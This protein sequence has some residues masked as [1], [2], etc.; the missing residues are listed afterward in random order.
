ME[1][2][3]LL[4]YQLPPELSEPLPKPK[5]ITTQFR[6]GDA[7]LVLAEG[8]ETKGT[9]YHIDSSY[10][11]VTIGNTAKPYEPNQIKP[12]SPPP[13]QNELAHSGNR[14]TIDWHQSAL[15]YYQNL[16][17]QFISLGASEAALG[18][19][20]RLA[21]LRHEISRLQDLANCT[22]QKIRDCGGSA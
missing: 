16:Q 17:A 9:I 8:T 7:V 13:P 14:Y 15:R 21:M 4:D 1:Q 20:P 12:F 22:K 19:T 5:P 10:I 6:Q 3:S 2:L 18:R 11:W